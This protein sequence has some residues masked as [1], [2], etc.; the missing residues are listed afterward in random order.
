M[1]P[2]VEA[3]LASKHPYAQLATAFAEH[4]KSNVRNSGKSVSVQNKADFPEFL[5]FH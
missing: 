3:A 4:I 2:A 5:F 1:D